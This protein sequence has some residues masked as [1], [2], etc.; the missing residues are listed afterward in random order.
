MIGANGAGKTTLLRVISGLAGA[1]RRPHDH[2]GRRPRRHAAA[3]DHRDRHRACA[4]EPA[5]VPAPAV[6]DNLRMGAFIP[7]AR[8]RSPSGSTTSITL[9]PRLKERRGQLAGTLSGGEQQMCAI[10]RA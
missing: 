4:G 1:D 5:A 3:Q 9:F 10:A 8:A 7:A 2:G 6:E